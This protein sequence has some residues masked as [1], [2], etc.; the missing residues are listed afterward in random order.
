MSPVVI[1][2]VSLV[3]AAM[4]GNQGCAIPVIRSEMTAI[5]VPSI[6]VA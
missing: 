5:T 3:S 1:R 6:T 4:R 2:H